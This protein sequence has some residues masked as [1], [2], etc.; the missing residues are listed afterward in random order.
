MATTSLISQSGLDGWIRYL[1]VAQVDY[2]PHRDP[3][4]QSDSEIALPF[5]P[6]DVQLVNNEKKTA[7]MKK[8]ADEAKTELIA[9]IKKWRLK[10]EKA[11]Q[12]MYFEEKY[13]ERVENKSEDSQAIRLDRALSRPPDPKLTDKQMEAKEIL[14]K[15]K[16]AQPQ[17]QGQ[18]IPIPQGQSIPIPIQIP[19]GQSQ[20]GKRQKISAAVDRRI[21]GMADL[22]LP[23]QIF[24]SMELLH[25]Q[26][27]QI[28]RT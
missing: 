5:T 23:E 15:R 20:Q 18:P 7:K 24:S 25:V 22:P 16:L 9:A 27:S 19:Q 6:S 26:P 21:H 4:L 12:Q 17:P 13:K 8:E 11:E 10:I 14:R 1:N 28:Q 2:K 3:L